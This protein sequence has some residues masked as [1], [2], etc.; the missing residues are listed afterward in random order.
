M[1]SQMKKKQNGEGI[2]SLLSLIACAVSGAWYDFIVLVLSLFSFCV[3]VFFFL[4]YVYVLLSY[5]FPLQNF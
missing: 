2:L 3:I 4:I 5:D 1:N